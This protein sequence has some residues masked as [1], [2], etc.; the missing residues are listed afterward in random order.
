MSS[1]NIEYVVCYQGTGR[2]SIESSN[3]NQLLSLIQQRFELGS[4]AQFTLKDENNLEFNS[5]VYQSH[6][7]LGSRLPE[8]TL[9]LLNIFRI[10]FMIFSPAQSNSFYLKVCASMKL[11]ELSDKIIDENAVEDSKKVCLFYASSGQPLSPSFYDSQFLKICDV[12][13]NEEKVYVLITNNIY[14]SQIIK[15]VNYERDDFIS[16]KD[17]LT[18]EEKY[19][20]INVKLDNEDDIKCEIG[21]AIGCS[22][23][24][25]L[26]EKKSETAYEYKIVQKTLNLNLDSYNPII[27]QTG[28]GLRLFRSFLYCLPYHTKIEY[29]ERL[30]ALIRYLI[31]FEPFINSLYLVLSFTSLTESELIAMDEGSIMLFEYLNNQYN[32]RLAYETLFE[33]TLD[34]FAILF[35]LADIQSFTKSESEKIETIVIVNPKKIIKPVIV[36]LTNDEEEIYDFSQIEEFKINSKEIPKMK[37]SSIYNLRVDTEL[38]KVIKRTEGIKRDEL[39]IIKTVFD[40]SFDIKIILRQGP[41]IS[42]PSDLESIKFK[43]SITQITSS[44]NLKNNLT[45]KTLTFNSQ[46]KIVV[47]LGWNDCKSN[48]IGLDIFSNIEYD[49]KSLA[50]EYVLENPENKNLL[51]MKIETEQEI[52]FRTPEEAICILLDTSESMFENFLNSGETK[53]K[54]AKDFLTSFVNRS[55]GYN[56][57]QIFSLTTFRNEIKKITKFTENSEIFLFH[58][59]NVSG[60]NTT[61][62]FDAVTS[63]I[64]DLRSIRLR[65]SNVKSRIICLSDRLNTQSETDM[66]VLLEELVSNQ[67][68]L[69]CVCLES[70]FAA[71]KNLSLC[72]GGFAF[73]FDSIEEG[74]KIFESDG[75]I[76]LSFRNPHKTAGNISDNNLYSRNFLNF[77]KIPPPFKLPIQIDFK[78]KDLKTALIKM[79][80]EKPVFINTSVRLRFK[81]IYRE[82]VIMHRKEHSFIEIYPCESDIQFWNAII[83]GPVGTPYEGGI[84]HIY[85]N[86]P[87]E[88]PYKPPEIRFLTKIFHININLSGRIFISV[89]YSRYRPEIKILRL[90]ES[91]YGLLMNPEATDSYE[92]TASSLFK[93]SREDYN[94]IAKEWSLNFANKPKSKIIDRI[95]NQEIKDGL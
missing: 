78:S 88:Y 75:F 68:V 5:E 60:T 92:T 21:F 7:L 47:N 26:Y 9:I 44:L 19:L 55:S 39:H 28:Q 16:I 14:T 54:V 91:I 17:Q 56:L 37:E 31:P 80:V 11:K 29:K 82:M 94:R 90:L 1:S 59:E 71:M 46:R 48:L 63:V 72:S 45:R 65:F 34:F 70:D 43:R 8:L 25:L 32:L 40:N 50:P 64:P 52:F 61:S 22:T 51:L 20:K 35:E 33:N 6:L 84:F 86:F 41:E 69:D 2:E 10:E 30:V 83:T 76:S 53:M 95:K 4:N 13:T 24:S 77:T 73:F 3:F 36:Q 58:L 79:E 27:A 93:S 85:I 89:L 15:S 12:L 42:N 23:N 87:D 67:I 49:L 57:P 18:K 81:R 38:Q 66:H 74:I 62:I